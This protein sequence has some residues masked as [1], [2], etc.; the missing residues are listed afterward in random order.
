MLPPPPYVVIM[1]I[2]CDRRCFSLNGEIYTQ[3]NTKTKKERNG[4]VAYTRLHGN[5]VPKVPFSEQGAKS[6]LSFS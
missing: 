3:L 4:R 2:L 1:F 5:A 6:Y